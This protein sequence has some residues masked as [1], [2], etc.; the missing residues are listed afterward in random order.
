MIEVHEYIP[1][2]VCS[3]NMK[4]KIEN[5]IIKD[6]DVIGGCSGNLQG[7]KQLI[8]NRNI[9]E[10][11]K[12]LEGIHCGYRDTSCPDQIARA[13]IEYETKRSN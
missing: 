10:V 4:F 11:I 13:L 8:L 3:K 9:D 12:L 1:T 6:F 5:N 7:I 2:G